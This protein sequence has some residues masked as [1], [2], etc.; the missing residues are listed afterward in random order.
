MESNC[1]NLSNE[2]NEYCSDY[3][4]KLRPWLYPCY[5]LGKIDFT[6]GKNILNTYILDNNIN[7][8]DIFKIKYSDLLQQCKLTQFQNNILDFVVKYYDYKYAGYKFSIS[9]VNYYKSKE[10]RIFDMKWLIDQDLKLDISKIPLYVTKTMLHTHSDTLYNVLN[11]KYY[12]GSLFKWIDECYPN[13]FIEL[14]FNINPYRSKFDSL[15]EAQVDEQ[16]RQKIGNIIHNERNRPDSINIMGMM[17]DWL[18]CLDNGIWLVEYWGLAR[19]NTNDEK[20][21]NVI[22]Y[23]NKMKEKKQKYGELLKVGYKHLYIYPEDLNN[24]FQGLHKKLEVIA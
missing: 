18:I 23:K 12:E 13:K 3:D 7:V 5:R 10:A 6:T 2:I 16:I 24:N 4:C 20:S 15:Q 1:S 8:N 22:Y 11:K 9:S 19:K 21:T 14:D 17:P